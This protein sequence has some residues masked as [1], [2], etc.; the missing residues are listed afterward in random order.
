VIKIAIVRNLI[1]LKNIAIASERVKNVDLAATVS[2]AII[3]QNTN[4]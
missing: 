1:V 4:K 2:V 3:I